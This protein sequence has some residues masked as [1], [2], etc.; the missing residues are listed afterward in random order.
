MRP[1]T[2]KIVADV[3]SKQIENSRGVVRN[4]DIGDKVITRNYS[5]KENKWIEGDIVE[6]TG[7]VSYKVLLNKGN[8]CRRHTDQMLPM[9]NSR[10]SWSLATEPDPSSE[11]SI[12]DQYV[13]TKPRKRN[14]K[15]EEWHSPGNDAEATAVQLESQKTDEQTM[16]VTP[17]QPLRLFSPTLPPDTD[18]LA[19]L[20]ESTADITERPKRACRLRKKEDN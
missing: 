18:G 10:F 15:I 7:P 2:S 12:N 14:N 5:T 3:Q 8:I 19:P 1:C 16:T 17:P 20:L 13:N 6:K 11:I 4:F 9:R